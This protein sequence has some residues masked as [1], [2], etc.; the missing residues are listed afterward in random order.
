MEDKKNTKYME[1]E[2]LRIWKIGKA[3]NQTKEPED[4]GVK[5]KYK[6]MEI[7]LVGFIVIRNRKKGYKV[8]A[9]K[10]KHSDKIVIFHT[11]KGREKE[12]NKLKKGISE[13]CKSFGYRLADSTEYLESI[14]SQKHVFD[15]M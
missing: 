12:A 8:A 15:K 7:T 11:F 10:I 14:Y 6:G 4:F 1:T 2:S 13:I 3:S 5:V 9:Y